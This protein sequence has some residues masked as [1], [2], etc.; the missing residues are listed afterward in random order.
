MRA[1]HLFFIGFRSGVKLARIGQAFFVKKFTLASQVIWETALDS[2][3]LQKLGAGKYMEIEMNDDLN[4]IFPQKRPHNTYLWE[5]NS[6]EAVASIP[7]DVVDWLLVEIWDADIVNEAYPETSLGIQ[8]AFILRDKNIVDLDGQLEN[9]NKIWI[10]NLIHLFA[11]IHF[12]LFSAID[13]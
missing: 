8:A 11:L 4:T 5:Y 13:L 6:S 12:Y 1:T 10:V 7:K 2:F 9:K 3:I